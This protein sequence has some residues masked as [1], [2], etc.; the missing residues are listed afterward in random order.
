LKIECVYCHTKAVTGDRAGFPSASK[1]MICHREVAKDTETIGRLAALAGDTLIV[2]EKPLYQLPDFV[3]FSHARHKT[4]QISCA[5]CHGDVWAEDIVKVQLRM[6][7]K[8][9]ID[10]H[11]TNHA[12]VVCN[13]CHE[14]TQ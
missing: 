11:K 4:Q 3:V 13:A 5:T 1:C 2:P 7:M 12:T 14:L 6:K 10:C 8:A 9:C